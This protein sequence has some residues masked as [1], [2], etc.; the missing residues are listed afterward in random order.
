MMH[1]KKYWVG[2]LKALR[3]FQKLMNKFEKR[4]DYTIHDLKMDFNKLE[5]L[6][7]RKKR[8]MTM[9]PEFDE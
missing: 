1:E 8:F 3:D 7:N 9:N 6:A 2:Y 5:E 4:H